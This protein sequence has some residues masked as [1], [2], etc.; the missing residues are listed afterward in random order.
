MKKYSVKIA[1]H[2]SSISLEEEF[3]IVLK[4]IA[5]NQRKSLNALVTEID[6]KKET[7]NLSSAIR[8]YILK[9]M[10]E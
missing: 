2:P 6:K 10:Q 1:N 7:D 9:H 4:N 5:Q 8:V 3:W